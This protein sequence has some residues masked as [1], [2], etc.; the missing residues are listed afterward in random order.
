MSNHS[1][2]DMLNE[3]LCKAEDMGI[4]KQIGKDKAVEFIL[5][6]VEIGEDHDCNSWEIL[7]NIGEKLG[8]CYGCLKPSDNLKYGLCKDCR[9]EED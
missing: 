3:V 8:I 9:S 7:E 2:S 5:A 1:G 4:F 6:L